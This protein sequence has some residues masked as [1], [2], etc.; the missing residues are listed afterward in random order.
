MSSPLLHFTSARPLPASIS[1]LAL[2][3]DPRRAAG[4]DRALLELFRPRELR[5]GKLP[6]GRAALVFVSS[7]EEA[8]RVGRLLHRSKIK[9]NV[10]GGRDLEAGVRKRRSGRQKAVLGMRQGK[11]QAL[12]CTDAVSRGLDFHNVTHVV[13]WD[14]PGARDGYVHRAGRVCRLGSEG[15]EAVVVNMVPEEAG[16]GLCAGTLGKLQRW[17]EEMNFSV[18][19]AGEDGAA[20]PKGQL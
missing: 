2:R 1:H 9:V 13:N 11:L 14:V 10:L 18:A 4:K 7:A 16:G 6:T 3:F 12:V 8:A 17:A 5:H 20:T 15:G 19:V